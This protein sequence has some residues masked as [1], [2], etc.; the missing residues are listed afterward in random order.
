MKCPN[1]S[2][3]PSILQILQAPQL[4]CS[5]HNSPD[6][7]KKSEKNTALMDLNGTELNEVRYRKTN[8]TWYHVHV[9]SK[10]L[11]ETENI[12][13]ATRLVAGLGKGEGAKD[14]KW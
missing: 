3:P 6:K 4:T 14:Q 11:I 8:T 7:A 2:S 5:V 13:M 12:F 10:E 9:E 1:N